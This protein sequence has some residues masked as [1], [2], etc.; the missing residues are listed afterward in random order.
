MIPLT[1]NGTTYHAQSDPE[2]P[3]LWVLRD[4]LGLKG[5]KY[6]CGVGVCGACLVLLDGAPAHACMVPLSNLA[7]R[8]VTTIEGL[9]GDHP[10][11]RAWLDEQV[12]QCGYCQPAQIL[13]AT[14]LL[15]ASP[16]PDDAEIDAALSGVFCRCGTYPRIRRAIH[17]AAQSTP[18]ASPLRLPELLDGLPADAGVALNEWIWVNRDNLVTLMINHSEM[19]QGSLTGLAVLFAEELDVDLDRL[20]TVFAP[21]A[22]HYEN[23][24]WGGQ[25]T[26]GS[27]SIR[28]EWKR[29][30]RAA[31]Q[32]RVRLVAAAARRWDVAADAC[33]TGQGAVTHLPSGRRLGYGEL[34][35]SAAQLEAPRTVP[36]KAAADFRLIGHSVP[37]LDIPAMLLGRARYGIDVAQHGMRVAAVAR[38]PVFGGRVRAFDA[39]AALA[40][41]QVCEVV[42]IASG[43][44]VVADDFWSAQRGCAAL[45]I[46]WSP[47]GNASLS[48]AK[49]EEKLL[50]ALQSQGEVVERRG[51]AMR[52]LRRAAE[53]SEAVYQTPYLAHA[54]IEPMNCVAHVQR[55]GCDIWVGTQ[56]QKRT[57]AR[58]AEI[59]GLPEAKVR[60]HTQFLGGG[61]GRR[62]ETDFVEEAVEL[63]RRLGRPVQV[64]WSRAD[65]LQHDFYRPAHAMRLQAC[66]DAH[67]LP[68][69]WFMRVAGASQALDGTQLPYAI[70]QLREE[71]VEV[72]SAVPTGAWRSVGASNNA[73][74]IEC[75]MDELAHAAGHDPVEFRLRL[76]DDAP[77]HR[78][79]LALAASKAGWG[80]P[81]A[82]GQ[83]RGVAVYQS[84]DAV[85]AQVAEVSVAEGVIRIKRVVCAI[86]CGIA[87]TPDA[88]RAQLEGSVAFGLSA[89]LHEEIRIAD[90]RVQQASLQ[91]YPLLSLAEMPA[92][93]VHILPSR[94]TPGGVGE[95]GVPVIAPAVAN[96]VFAATGQRLRRLPLRLR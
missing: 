23:G 5:T 66:L 3:L 18:A 91:D 80:K 64:V 36:L 69:A 60:V 82:P 41:P 28:G 42:P 17:R 43:I 22:A 13:A 95:P 73:F 90:G 55:D 79:T 83:G 61:F 59:T 56:D 92:V 57:R 10:V 30:R 96:A 54:T 4:E 77:R 89:A 85:V 88:I 15:R 52:T 20:R 72:A 16:H 51:D 53:V 2:K 9:P 65:D 40:M 63:S 14:A 70:P 67:G 84:F 81:M 71:R 78:A 7:S 62:L 44:A 68:A 37:R 86:E 49:I 24:L 26:G 12:P 25:F 48:D 50:N 58:A 1:V 35:E 29:L 34:A 87:V 38:C 19:G 6:G 21:V 75:F 39:S 8:Q 76:L 33:R 46:D 32:V 27:S 47:G 11:I 45:R 74:A 93:E 94:R 31:A